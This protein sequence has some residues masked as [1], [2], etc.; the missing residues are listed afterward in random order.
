[1]ST[2]KNKKHKKPRQ[3]EVFHNNSSSMMKMNYKID[4][5]Q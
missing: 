5:Y 4:Y 2:F 3:S 1:M